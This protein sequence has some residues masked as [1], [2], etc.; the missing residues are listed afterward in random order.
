MKKKLSYFEVSLNE[1]LQIFDSLSRLDSI[2][3]LISDLCCQALKRGNK[4][5]FIGNGGSAADA[6][7]I[8]A[9]FTGRFEK[10]RD[11]IAALALTTDNSALTSIG[12]DYDFDCI[13]SRQI[14]A[15]VK[16]GDI[17]FLISTSG[18]SKNIIKALEAV[19]QTGS[20][21][22][23]LT[24][25]HGSYFA[26]LCDQSLLVNSSV[27]ARIQEAHMFLLH[28]LCGMVELELSDE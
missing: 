17:V 15:L 23:A 13:F 14:K 1:H 21:P 6:Q 12:N 26:S 20:I 5:V 7:H 19:R 24:G 3:V 16:S 22:I 8:A 28:S 10:E 18:K 11:P 9:E 27:T 4:L 25:E 2:L